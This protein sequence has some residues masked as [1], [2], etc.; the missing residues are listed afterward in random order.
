MITSCK[1]SKVMSGPIGKRQPQCLPV[2]LNIKLIGEMRCKINRLIL[3]FRV[4]DQVSS[5]ECANQG[6]QECLA[7]LAGVMNELEEAEVDR[8]FFLRDAAMRAQ[9]GAQ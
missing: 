3:G 1:A 8:K 4:L 6:A 9:P 2:F 5:D 7:S